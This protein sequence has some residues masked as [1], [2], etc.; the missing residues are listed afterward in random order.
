MY[1]TVVTAL[2]IEAWKKIT[3]KRSTMFALK[4][5]YFSRRDELEKGLEGEHPKQREQVC[6]V[7]LTLIEHNYARHCCGH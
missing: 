3:M 5:R 7:Q 1:Y 2:I 6:S 4:E